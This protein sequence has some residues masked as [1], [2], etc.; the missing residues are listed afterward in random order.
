MRNPESEELFLG[1]NTKSNDLKTQ[2]V[3]LHDMII[4]RRVFLLHVDE[5]TGQFANSQHYPTAR[6]QGLRCEPGDQLNK[7]SN[8]VLISFCNLITTIPVKKTCLS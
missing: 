8:G 3:I 1:I 4:V 2:S 7:S 6:S 5:L